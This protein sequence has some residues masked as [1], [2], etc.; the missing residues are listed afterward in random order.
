MQRSARDLKPRTPDKKVTPARVQR[1]AVRG[2][3]GG[4]LPLGRPLL[5][6]HRHVLQQNLRG[7]AS[8]QEPD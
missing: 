1:L 6:W 2:Q 7:G 3:L 8:G 4:I 5:L